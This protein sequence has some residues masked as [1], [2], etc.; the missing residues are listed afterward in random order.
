MV[1]VEPARLRGFCLCCKLLHS[2]ETFICYILQVST[3]EKRPKIP[4]KKPKTNTPT[5]QPNP[6]GA[7]GEMP[8]GGMGTKGQV[9]II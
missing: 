9:V 1:N 8:W 4:P 3:R 6:K 5:Q 7:T 2:A